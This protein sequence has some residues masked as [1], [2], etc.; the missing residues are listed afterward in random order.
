MTAILRWEE[1][2]PSGRG[3]APQRGYQRLAGWA[4]VLEEVR[5]GDGR[6]ACIYDGHDQSLAWA[7]ATQIRA[8]T[9]LFSPG[10]EAASR[11]IGPRV[12]R[13]YARYLAPEEPT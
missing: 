1:P 12:F 6:W 3:G 5:R 9:A 2:P 7:L 8:A 10:F 4:D 13:T 11:R